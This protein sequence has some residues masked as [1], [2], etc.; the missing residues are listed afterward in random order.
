[1]RP[2]ESRNLQDISPDMRLL[3]LLMLLALPLPAA[4]EL[5][6]W[7]DEKGQVTYSDQ[8]P[9]ASIKEVQKRKLGN[10]VFTSE[11]DTYGA[12]KAASDFPV[13]IYTG[14]ACGKGC[15]DARAY[16]QQRGIPFTERSLVTDEDAA[17]YRKALG[18]GP[19]FAPALTV[20]SQKLKGF[21][22][23]GWE[24]LLDEAGYPKAAAA[25]PAQ[26]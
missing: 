23:S 15:D 18:D 20:G 2:A 3:S 5:Y 13:V 22:K 19:L 9:P 17:A 24:K 7:V 16:L 8:P 12:R 14:Q 26:P 10:N 11:K 4:A 25:K 1:M 21:E 6:R